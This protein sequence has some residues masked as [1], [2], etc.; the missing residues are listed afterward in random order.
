LLIPSV[1]EAH[2]LRE[3]VR[4]VLKGIE[5]G[6]MKKEAEAFVRRLCVGD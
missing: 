4:R 1:N 5:R 6:L 3:C 2:N